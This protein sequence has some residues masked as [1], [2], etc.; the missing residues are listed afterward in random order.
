[1]QRGGGAGVTRPGD[2]LRKLDRACTEVCADAVNTYAR[3]CG[4]GGALA[5]GN[6]SVGGVGGIGTSGTGGGRGSMG[7]GVP[8]SGAGTS[9]AGLVTA[10]AA[11]LDAVSALPEG[12]L[13]SGAV[14]Y[15][16]A[17]Y[18]KRRRVV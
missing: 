7:G 2:Y 13:G 10:P 8:G 16:P 17:A 3:R 5:G 14:D 15:L 4:G 9:G 11:D 1:M 12:I 18:D 6:S